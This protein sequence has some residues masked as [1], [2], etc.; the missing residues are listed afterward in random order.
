MHPIVADITQEAQD[1]FQTLTGDAS[2]LIA[3]VEEQVSAALDAWGQK[4]VE[5]I[6]SET[7]E[8]PEPASQHLACP[9]CQK[10]GLRRFRRRE[11]NFTTIC[12]VV[13]LKRWEYKCQCGHIHVPWE[14][15]QHLKGQYTQKVAEVM[16]RLAAQLNYRA[17]AAELKHQGIQVSHTTLHKKVRQW[18]E[19]EE[20]SEYVDKQSLEVGARWYVSSD[21]CHTNSL[22]GYKEIKVGCVSKDYPHTNA[23]SVIKTRPSTPRYVASQSQAV[24]FGQQLAAL[25]TQ[26]GIYQ[27]ETTMDT[28][29]VVVIGDGAPWIWNLASEHFPHATE[30]L[31][32]MHAKRHLY[33]LAKE[34]FGEDD[35]E[36][37]DTWVDTIETPLYDGE[38]AQVVAGIRA[39][40]TQHPGIG[41]VL[42]KEVGYF[43]KHAHRM[44]YRWFNEKGYQ[45]G[46]GVIESACKHI[47]AERC[48][49][50]GMRWTQP[51]INAILF[52]RCLLK[53]GAWQTYW[54][55]QATETA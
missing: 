53:N 37:V 18:S 47:V 17:A 46:S 48:K 11:R 49:Q 38:T 50:A 1:I 54:D 24:D 30:I 14:A 33:D 36:A 27:D 7:A 51:G 41:D 31:D 6:V 10:Q 52:W 20:T 5:A 4:L 44:R 8:H 45:I 16:M 3:D 28:Q 35:R 12:G 25:A 32:Y 22:E 39:L 43:Q 9:S 2:V 42:E 21:G 34:A 15:R 26:T 13:R 23:T 19:G 55:K 29:E 40:E